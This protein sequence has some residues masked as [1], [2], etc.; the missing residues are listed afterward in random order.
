M[1]DP[2]GAPIRNNTIHAYDILNLRCHSIF[3][4]LTFLVLY[5]ISLKVLYEID[6]L[7]LILLVVVLIRRFLLTEDNCEILK[8][9]GE[10]FD[11]SRLSISLKIYEDKSLSLN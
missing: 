2:M 7:L 8:V 3:A 4:F 9:I 11:F 5:F 6:L 10:I 1:I